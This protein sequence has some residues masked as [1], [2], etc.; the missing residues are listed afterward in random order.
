MKALLLLIALAA[1]SASPARADE[2][3]MR[4]A[5]RRAVATAPA[6]AD[7]TD[8]LHVVS[9]DSLRLHGYDKPLR[10]MHETFFAT[11]PGP[12]TISAITLDIIYRTLDGTMLHARRVRMACDIPPGQTRQLRTPAWDRQQRHYYHLT[13]SH[14]A[15]PRAV[16]FTVDLLPRSVE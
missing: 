7:I 13:R 3:T 6:P 8:T 1:A 11:N 4:P 10:S 2:N 5:L 15:S 16:P 9:A 12:H 14:P